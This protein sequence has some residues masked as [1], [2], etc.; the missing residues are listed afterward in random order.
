[1]IPLYNVPGTIYTL[2]QLLFYVTRVAKFFTK[3][4]KE[5]TAKFENKQL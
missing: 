5:T 4:S 1:M 3:V 2:A